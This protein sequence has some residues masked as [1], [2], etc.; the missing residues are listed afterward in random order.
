MRLDAYLSASSPELASLPSFE[1][2]PAAPA[3]PKYVAWLKQLAGVE[4]AGEPLAAKVAAPAGSSGSATFYLTVRVAGDLLSPATRLTCLYVGGT[5]WE[6]PPPAAPPRPTAAPAQRRR[7]AVAEIGSLRPWAPEQGGTAGCRGCPSACA[8][9]FTLF[10]GD[11]YAAGCLVAGYSLRRQGCAHDLVVLVTPDVSLACRARLRCVFN[12][13]REVDYLSARVAGM[14]TEKQARARFFFPESCLATPALLNKH[15][16]VMQE[17]KYAEWMDVSFTRYACLQLVEYRSILLLDAD[18]LALAN[19]DELFALEA[20]AGTFSTPWALPFKTGGCF[21][22]YVD[23]AGRPL[24][25]GETI[26][27]GMVAA[28]LADGNSFVQIG[29]CVLLAPSVGDFEEFRQFVL[30]RQ[31]FGLDTVN[32]GK[33]EQSIAMFYHEKRPETTWRM[34]SPEFGFIPWH[35]KWLPQGA[36]SGR[37]TLMHLS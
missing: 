7:E 31:P 25:H 3:G 28:A 17:K 23:A 18:V 19:M 5:P 36:R 14:R 35:K 13:I 4:P 10:R 22:P 26:T 11:A 15:I 27:H 32:S 37:E 16:P 6:P 29:N 12:V 9:V 30:A 21:N 2:A 24:P 1:L 8:Y 20:P 34:I 33:D